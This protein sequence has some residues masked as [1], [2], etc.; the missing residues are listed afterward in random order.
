[1]GED[2]ASPVDTELRVKGLGNVRVADASVMPE[3]PVS[4]LNA[5]SMMIGFRAAD[6][7]LAE[8]AHEYDSSSVG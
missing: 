3:I 2:E 7:I 5:P 4:A 6:F 1:M 8:N